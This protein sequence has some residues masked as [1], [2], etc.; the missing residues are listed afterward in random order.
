MQ[1]VSFNLNQLCEQGNRT[2]KPRLIEHETQPVVLLSQQEYDVLMENFYLLSNPNNA[3]KLLHS[4]KQA[5]SGNLQ[6]RGLL[7]D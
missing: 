3:N 7:E 6:K 4:L 5:R 2:N 1:V